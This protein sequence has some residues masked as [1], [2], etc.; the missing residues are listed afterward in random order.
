MSLIESSVDWAPIVIGVLGAFLLFREVWIAQEV[1]KLAPEIARI[2][3]LD[4]LY[5][6][7]TDEFVVRSLM[8]AMGWTDEVA[9]RILNAFGGDA[10]GSV[11]GEAFRTVHADEWAA[12]TAHVSPGLKRWDNLTQPAALSMR[13]WLLWSGFGLIVLAA[14]IQLVARAAG[15]AP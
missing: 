6:T 15:V 13:R 1:E 11:S 2:K 9:R 7:D 4:V 14:V 10:P 5:H 3:E 8:Y 12:W